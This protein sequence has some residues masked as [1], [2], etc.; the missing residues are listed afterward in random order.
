MSGYPQKENGHPENDER[1][2]EK[3]EKKNSSKEKTEESELKKCTCKQKKQ[4]LFCFVSFSRKKECLKERTRKC[5]KI[6]IPKK[7]KG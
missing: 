4:K 3:E 7:K 5:F 6:I 2:R 1:E